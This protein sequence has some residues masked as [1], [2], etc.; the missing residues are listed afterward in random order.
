MFLFIKQNMKWMKM[1]ISLNTSHVLIYQHLSVESG[2]NMSF[3]YI[4]CSYLSLPCILLPSCLH[5]FKYISCSYLSNTSLKL[6]YPCSGLNTSHVLIY[7]QRQNQTK[8][9]LCSLNTSHVLIYRNAGSGTERPVESL[10]T[11][12]VLIYRSWIQ[13]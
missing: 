10:N 8:R 9:R 1:V 4:S 5:S 2:M 12:H 6:L 11:S 7:L 3:K 13:L